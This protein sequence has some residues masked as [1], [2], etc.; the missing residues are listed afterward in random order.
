[1]L[2]HQVLHVYQYV[3]TDGGADILYVLALFFF[4]PVLRYK[5]PQP[6][7]MTVGEFS[8]TFPS[9]FTRQLIPT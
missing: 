6:C 1:M 9:A 7:P 5:R 4:A 3:Q 8:Q 2:K